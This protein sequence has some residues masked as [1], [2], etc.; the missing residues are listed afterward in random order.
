[1]LRTSNHANEL[2]AVEIA[3]SRARIVID[4]AVDW[5]AANV[6]GA[7]GEDPI[8]VRVFARTGAEHAERRARLNGDDSSSFPSTQVSILL[9][10]GDLVAEVGDKLVADVKVGS[11]SIE[12]NVEVVSRIQTQT[13]VERVADRI[14]RIGTCVAA[15]PLQSKARA[16]PQ[17]HLPTVIARCKRV[18]TEV[19]ACDCRIRTA[20]TSVRP[21][22][23]SQRS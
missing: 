18:R 20:R 5:P 16:M 21:A 1:L 8:G 14:D 10:E 11:P 13:G 3:V 19:V 22:G 12:A 4:H 17:D 9:H 6:H 23:S 15:I 2:T 7:I